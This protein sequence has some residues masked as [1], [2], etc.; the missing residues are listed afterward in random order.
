MGL[1][2]ALIIV[3]LL[4]AAPAVRATLDLFMLRLMSF[5]RSLPL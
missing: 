5:F 3:V 1:L 2:S 4:A